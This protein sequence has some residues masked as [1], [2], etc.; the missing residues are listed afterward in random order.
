MH[1]KRRDDENC[2]RDGGDGKNVIND[3][4]NAQLEILRLLISAGAINKHQAF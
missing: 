2:K 3:T 4:D 1:R